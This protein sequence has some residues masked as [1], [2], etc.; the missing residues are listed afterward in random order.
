MGSR[1]LKDEEMFEFAKI[2]NLEN[3]IV[4]AGW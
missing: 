4:T 3:Y 1:T 2:I